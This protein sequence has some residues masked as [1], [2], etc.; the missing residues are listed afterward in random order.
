MITA[1]LRAVT[2]YPSQFGT[3]K[4]FAAELPT[5]AHFILSAVGF[6]VFVG[7]SP[8]Q[9]RLTSTLEALTRAP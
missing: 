8:E 3:P 5:P 6:R 2:L 7:G 1:S 9:P 4:Y